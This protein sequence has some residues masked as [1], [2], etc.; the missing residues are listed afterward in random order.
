VLRF[1]LSSENRQ[2]ELKL[3]PYKQIKNT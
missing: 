2:Q 1:L 3:L